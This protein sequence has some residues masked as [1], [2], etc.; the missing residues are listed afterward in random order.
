MSKVVV[1]SGASDIGPPVAGAIVWGSSVA[2]DPV[3]SAPVGEASEVLCFKVVLSEGARVETLG[4]TV[5]GTPVGGASVIGASVAGALVCGASVG[6]GDPVDSAPVG[7]ASLVLCFKVVVFAGPGV[8]AVGVM[9]EGGASVE[10]ASVA[11]DP[12][13][14]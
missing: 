5:E 13:G 1:S 2:R 12:V 7:E 6:K 10:G 11:A 8:E 3:D 14:S 9:P 4:S